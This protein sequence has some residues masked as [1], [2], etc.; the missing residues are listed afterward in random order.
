MSIFRPYPCGSHERQ[1][2]ITIFMALPQ[3]D[4]P[5]AFSK[6]ADFLVPPVNTEHPMIKLGHL[7]PAAS[8]SPSPAQHNR[9]SSRNQFRSQ[10][11]RPFFAPAHGAAST[12]GETQ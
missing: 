11:S 4:L 8:V 12:A 5:S 7:I 6:P 2:P 3:A 10:A 9:M 1:L